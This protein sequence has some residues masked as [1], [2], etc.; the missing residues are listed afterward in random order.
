MEILK[1]GQE[2]AKDGGHN[3]GFPTKLETEKTEQ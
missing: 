3:P 1:R 2:R